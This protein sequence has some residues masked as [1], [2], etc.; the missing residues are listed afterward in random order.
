MMPEGPEV[1][2]LVDQ[3]QGGVG[4]RVVDIQFL[5]GRYVPE[6]PETFKAFS[7]TMTPAFQPHL[8]LPEAIDIIQEWTA[9]GKFIYIALDGGENRRNPP[10]HEERAEM[11]EEDD[12]QRSIW[13]TLG[14]SGRFVN[15]QNHQQNPRFARWYL[16]LL[17]L[18]TNRSFKIYYHDQRSFG[19]LKFCLSK[20]ELVKKLASL[21]P[22]IL[23]PRTTQEH[24]MEI[25]AK[26]RPALNICKFLMDQ[27][28]ICGVGNYILA[29]ALY[30]AS[31]D[32]F[33]SLDE[34]S[35]LQQVHLFQEIQAIA[36]ESYDAQGLTRQGGTFRNVEGGKGQFEFQLQCYGRKVCANGNP[37]IRDTN[38][39]HKRTIWY[40]ERQLFM[41]VLARFSTQSA[42]NATRPNNKSVSSNDGI[43]KG[44]MVQGN[45]EMREAM[46][47]DQCVQ[48]LISGLVE[49]SWK[50]ALAH[51]IDFDSFRNLASFIH[52]ERT[53]GATI[54]P[55][56][57]DIFSALNLC[58]LEKVKVVIVGQD[59]Y[60]GPGQGHGLAF[61]VRRGV[62]PP[63]SL[64]N[65]VKE[66]MSDVA[67]DEPRHG[68]LEHWAKQGV[69]LLNTVMTVRQGEANSHAKRGWEDFTDAVIQELNEK[70]DG[71]V[72]LL[73]GNPAA[74]KATGVDESKHTIIG[75]SHPSPLGATKTSAPF[76]SSRCFSRTNQALEAK[77]K[78]PID[79]SVI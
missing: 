42:T 44:Q 35:E 14:M 67:I 56:Q 74:K 2:T 29:E 41:P 28:K 69:L 25:V 30:R 70:G 10:I 45:D 24:F 23:H 64:K 47:S 15:E 61:S 63:P 54:Y 13:I 21:G 68:N 43:D 5:S 20:G 37:V 52:E 4:K 27:S 66:A 31:I 72:F 12:F 38:G 62:R 19:T 50:K 65:I 57:E 51:A 1:R 77:G 79:W 16:E 48:N 9:K 46:D 3:L 71:V 76:T 7:R 39:P 33:C 26:Q 17:D 32:P 59:P 73:W 36:R 11:L 58:P 22:D 49:P 75:S 34:L 8:N 78:T 18:S 55:P 40:T 6:K 60:H 53:S